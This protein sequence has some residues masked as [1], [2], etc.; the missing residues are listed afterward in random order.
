MGKVVKRDL[1]LKFDPLP[2][3]PLPK[4]KSQGD[5]GWLYNLMNALI[6]AP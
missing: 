6:A 1:G 5:E 2:L 3:F 4:L